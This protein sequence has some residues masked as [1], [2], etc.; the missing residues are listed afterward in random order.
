MSNIDFN[1]FCKNHLL[2]GLLCVLKMV[3]LSARLNE[4]L[5]FFK[6]EETCAKKETIFIVYYS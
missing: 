6:Y 5:Q 3:S 2:T 1:D 4:M